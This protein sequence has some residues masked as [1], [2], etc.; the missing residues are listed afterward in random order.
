MGLDYSIEL[1]ITHLKSNKKVY[2]LEIAYWRKAWG[3]ARLFQE[4]AMQP[5]N[6]ISNDEDFKTECYTWVLSDII[7]NISVLINDPDNEVW[8]DSL[9]DSAETRYFT[10]KNLANLC[11]ARDWINHT[12]NDDLLPLMS[13]ESDGPEFNEDIYA[14]F[15]KNPNDYE[16]RIVFY[17]SY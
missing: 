7:K 10:I 8:T 16:V 12:H 6:K 3:L 4:I 13:Y 5:Q 17:N 2:C 1:E 15:V 11:A 14:D 9:W